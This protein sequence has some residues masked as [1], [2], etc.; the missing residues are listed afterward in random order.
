MAATPEWIGRPW[1]NSV[2]YSRTIAPPHFG[3]TIGSAIRFATIA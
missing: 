1:A 3:H 2:T